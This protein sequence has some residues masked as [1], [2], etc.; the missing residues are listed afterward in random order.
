[1]GPIFYRW[2][3]RDDDGL[4]TPVLRRKHRMVVPR[5]G[6]GDRLIPVKSAEKFCECV[7]RVSS[8]VGGYI[9]IALKTL[10]AG[11]VLTPVIKANDE[12]HFGIAHIQRQIP[13]AAALPR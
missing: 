7:I 4:C 12:H 5:G 11:V 9:S 3:G 2:I 6:L 8:S 1:M 10:W 13:R